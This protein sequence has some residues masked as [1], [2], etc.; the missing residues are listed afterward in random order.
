MKVEIIWKTIAISMLV[1]T[2]AFGVSY[3]ILN[4]SGQRDEQEPLDTAPIIEFDASEPWDNGMNLA[5]IPLDKG[6]FYPYIRTGT[7][8]AL[9]GW[10][11][12]NPDKAVVSFTGDSSSSLGG[13]QTGWLIIYEVKE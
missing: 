6:N 5:W 4:T 3:L 2:V 13:G 11:N 12:D 8:D 10:I 1:L 7:L 9:Q